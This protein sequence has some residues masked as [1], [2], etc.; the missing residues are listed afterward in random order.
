MTDHT[1][2]KLSN[3]LTD[4]QRELWSRLAGFPFDDDL[5]RPFSLRLAAE[6]GWTPEFTRRVLVEY[7]RF[8]FL[9]AVA[10]HVVCPSE[11]V[12]AA[13][14][15]HLTYSRSY[16]NDL[17]HQ[18]L[19]YP[20]HH[21]PTAGGP[22][23]ARRHWDMYQ[24]T[25]A[26]YRRIFGENPPADIWPS[27]FER[28]DPCSQ[29]RVVN[30]RDHWV[31]RKPIWWPKRIRRRT[32]LAFAMVPLAALGLN[33]LN[34]PGPEFLWLFF[35]LFAFAIICSIT[36]RCWQS[37]L[38]ISEDRDLTPEEIACLSFGRPA[39]VNVVVAQM[40]HQRQLLSL[41]AKGWFVPIDGPKVR[42]TNGKTAPPEEDE[43]ATAIYRAVEYAPKTLRELQ[44]SLA[45][46]TEAIQERLQSAGY[47]LDKSQVWTTRLLS[48][49]PFVCL[50]VLGIAK[51]V[52]GLNRG[53][54]VE[55][56]AMICF[57]VVMVMAIVMATVGR[58]LAG[59]QMLRSMKSKY[60]DLKSKLTGPDFTGPQV[61]LGAALFGA[62]ALDDTAFADLKSAWQ[63]KA[64]GASGSSSGCGGSGCGGGGCGGGGCGGGGC[65]GCGGG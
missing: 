7:R 18:T 38:T 39:T 50:L 23:E 17:C 1:I 32:Q 46:K 60:A 35:G 21:D 56:L 62:V 44:E 42:F 33:P 3:E 40:L 27:A 49:L 30:L 26:S 57:V 4:P 36:I 10:G 55:F 5:A 20:L 45:L 29:P 51:V 52:V 22:A 65:G 47:L 59:S 63:A 61:A 25:L 13:W 54:P 15:Q 34:W 28:F 37:D 11:D 8:L 58:S 12:D 48:S 14:H 6:N 41:P 9:T 2:V 19:G 16:W 64:G 53:R 31:L 24:Q 43:L